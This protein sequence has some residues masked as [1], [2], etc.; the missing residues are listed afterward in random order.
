LL[1]TNT[2][3]SAKILKRLD[4]GEY[5]AFFLIGA[6]LTPFFYGKICFNKQAFSKD[7]LFKPFEDSLK[8]SS[9]IDT[10]L[11][12]YGFLFMSDKVGHL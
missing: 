3:C 9:I 10:I 2:I 5:L 8:I 11:I 6:K 1:L 12:S 7:K 4:D